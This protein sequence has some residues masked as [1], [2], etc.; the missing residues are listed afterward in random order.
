MF[1]FLYIKLWSWEYLYL[2]RPRIE[3]TPVMSIQVLE[4]DLQFPLGYKLYVIRHI[5]YVV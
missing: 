5:N 3:S 4:F 2:E 1:F